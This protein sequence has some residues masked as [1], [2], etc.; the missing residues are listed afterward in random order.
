MK[1]DK[2]QLGIDGDQNI[3]AGGD[4]Y[5]SKTQVTESSFADM[6]RCADDL[7]AT[8]LNTAGRLVR[9][10]RSIEYSSEMLVTSLMRIGI[11]LK[12]SIAIP[13]RVVNMLALMLDEREDKCVLT[14]SDMRVAVVAVIRDLECVHPEAE[15]W[16]AAYI[17]RYGDPNQQFLRVVDN[18]VE[19][20]LDYEYIENM[21]LPHL[22]RRILGMGQEDDPRSELSHLFSSYNLGKMSHEIVRFVGT[23]DVYGIRYKTLLYLLEDIVVGPPHPWLVNDATRVRVTAYNL[24]RA[25]HHLK[26]AESARTA[27][28]SINYIQSLRSYFQHVCGAILSQYGVFLGIGSKYGLLELRRLLGKCRSDPSLREIC[29]IAQL[30]NALRGAGFPM[31]TLTSVLDTVVFKLNQLQN[32]YDDQERAVVEAGLVDKAQYIASIAAAVCVS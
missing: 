12:V 29:G 14:T 19:Y 17:R 13:F 11:P 28:K 2:R 3:V 6:F 10:A 9:G 30:E 15:W 24:E 18:D 5:L 4:I 23:L 25:W 31:T 16:C 21:I 1:G 32:C 20:D 26:C 27:G 22:F 7:F 8:K